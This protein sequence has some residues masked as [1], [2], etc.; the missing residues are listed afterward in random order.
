MKKRCL[1]YGTMHMILFIKAINLSAPCFI[2][3][4]NLLLFVQRPTRHLCLPQNLRGSC[5]CLQP[6]YKYSGARLQDIVTLCNAFNKTRVCVTPL[7]QMET[8]RPLM[9]MHSMKD[10]A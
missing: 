9:S 8:W 1:L 6:F 5:A 7:Y 4:Y 2:E 3:L 10:N